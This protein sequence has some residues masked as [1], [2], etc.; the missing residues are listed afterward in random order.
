MTNRIKILAVILLSTL[1]INK[2]HC[3]ETNSN[4]KNRFD[5]IHISLLTC[6]PH[7]EVYSLYGH[8]AIRYQDTA[9][10]VD[11][12][13]NYGVFSFNEPYF[14]P[15]F[16][17]GMTDY[18]MGIC[19][20]SNFCEEYI[21]YGANVTQQELNLT[22]IE[23]EAIF[24]ALQK[25]TLP[26]NIKYRY[27]YLYNNC[28]TKARNILIGNIKDE[29]IFENRIDNS[30]SF[31]D[32]IHSCLKDH[33][34]ARFGNDLL[35]G[36]KADQKT[37]RSDQ[38]FLPANLMTDFSHARIKRA[39]KIVP[40]I[41]STYTVVKSSHT[42]KDRQTGWY[43]TPTYC[44]IAI[45]LCILIIVGI[46]QKKRIYLWGFDLF[47]ALLVGFP[48]IILTL[49]IFSQH[50]TVNLNLQILM[51]NPMALLIIFHL[52]RHRKEYNEL[53]KMWKITALFLIATLLCSII[54]TFAEG[55]VILASSLLLR[56]LYNIRLCGKLTKKNEK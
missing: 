15:R 6:S 24:I 4:I 42:E 16:I 28:T 37:N 56:V 10:G 53:Q 27:N 8:T 47:L 25:N 49:M 26:E 32:I 33:V 54:Q 48:G 19:D 35:L 45:L 20:F 51:L 23:K 14:I 29:V 12:A 34:W 9:E 46:E 55:M 22:P 17:L 1:S 39:G 2:I 52:I 5:S 43:P 41:K 21:Y 11:L 18:E 13:I 40:L 36:I 7:D 38:Q 3:M 44:S 50:P 31:R 30:I